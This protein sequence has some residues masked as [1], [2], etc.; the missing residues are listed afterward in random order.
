MP[1]GTTPGACVHRAVRYTDG[2]RSV[3]DEFRARTVGRVLAL[4][5]PGRIELALK[6]GDDD[7]TLFLRSSGMARDAALRVLRA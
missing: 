4:S 3:A 2:V 6:L 1:S 5:V 7:L